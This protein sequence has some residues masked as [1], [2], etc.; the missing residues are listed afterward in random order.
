MEK[1]T[2]KEDKN[3]RDHSEYIQESEQIV[4]YEESYKARLAG[5]SKEIAH[6]VQSETKVKR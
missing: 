3:A 6:I 5:F 2:K 1:V 4:E